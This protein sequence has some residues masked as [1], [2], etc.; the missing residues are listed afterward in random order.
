LNKGDDHH[1]KNAVFPPPPSG[2][3]IVGD[4]FPLVEGVRGR[5]R[6]HNAVFVVSPLNVKFV[7]I[8]FLTNHIN[9]YQYCIKIEKLLVKA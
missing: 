4:N 9:I 2:N 8:K 7:S 5:K 6:W 1:L 3:S